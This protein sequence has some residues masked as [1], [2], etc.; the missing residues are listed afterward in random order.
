MPKVSV[1]IAAYNL[2]AYLPETI[3]NVLAQTYTDFELIVVDDGSSD[4]TSEWVDQVP[5]PR[6]RLITQTNMGLA[7]ASNTGII[8]SQGEYITFIDADDLWSPTKLEQQVK[9]L[10]RHP[11]VGIVYT[12][13]TYMN[14]AGE[15][16]GRVVKPEADGYIWQDLI[17]V[18]QIECGSVVMVRRSCFDEVG[19]FHT[20]LNAYGQDWDMWLRLA[21]KY[22]FK[23]IRQPLVYYRQRASS[24]SRHLL[25]M[26]QGFRVV[27]AKAYDAAPSELKPLA[28]HGYGFAY[29]CLAWKALQ[30]TQP[31]YEAARK[32]HQIAL[33]KDPQRFWT[34]ENLRLTIAIALMRIFG[35]QNYFKIL[36]W[37][38]SWRSKLTPVSAINK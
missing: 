12:W 18:N 21:L 29:F 11:E 13:V 27:L 37:M 15:S 3:N 19:L 1:I 31:D 4:H 6:V 17:K 5:D 34:K 9:I 25:Q 16:T 20:E 10:D 32:Y 8:N 36:D 26:E 14:D 24:S 7:G 2:M 33:T 28:N 30:N 38:Q 35:Q 22:Q 23:V